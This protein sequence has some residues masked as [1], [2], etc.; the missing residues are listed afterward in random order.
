MRFLLPW[1]LLIGL[2]CSAKTLLVLTEPVARGYLG[3]WLDR[4]ADQ[5]RRE[6][7]YSVIYIQEV[8]RC[9]RITNANRLQVVN[10]MSNL[11]ARYMPDAVQVIGGAAWDIGGW[12]NKD[13][14]QVRCNVTDARLMM[15]NA[16]F[17]DTAEWGMDGTTILASNHPGDGRFDELSST[18]FARPLA[19][20]DFSG[21][22][23]PHPDTNAYRFGSGCLNGQKFCPDINEQWALTN[24]VARNL[25]YR[26]RDW[27]PPE[28]GMVLGGLYSVADFTIISTNASTISWSQSST[29]SVGGGQELRWWAHGIDIPTE[30]NDA[31]DGDCVPVRSVLMSV[32]R[33]YGM[34]VHDGCAPIFRMMANGYALCGVWVRGSLFSDRPWWISRPS[35]VV[36]ADM[37]RTSLNAAGGTWD[38][39]YWMAGD[40]TL[41]IDAVTQAPPRRARVGTAI[42]GSISP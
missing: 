12:H 17:T 4:W 36:V 1:L 2:H 7:V 16:T 10:Q 23:D 21:L 9:A 34:Q 38:Y 25:Q 37:F 20:I 39:F 24:Y 40:L 41:P 8:D 19:R 26:Q 33:S 30:G 18:N 42:V 29:M 27:V 14:H 13:G 32:Y 11:I 6:G 28:E 31:F 22:Y 15:T 3:P 35:D 5:V